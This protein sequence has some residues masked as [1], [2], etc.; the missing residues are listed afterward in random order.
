MVPAVA[1]NWPD[2]GGQLPAWR[3][4][5]R[6]DPASG[7][8]RCP[9]CR[10]RKREADR[11]A[12]AGTARRP[13]PERCAGRVRPCLPAGPAGLSYHAPTIVPAAWRLRISFVPSIAFRAGGSRGPGN[14]LPVWPVRIHR[15]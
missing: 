11:R 14:R 6:Y 15:D 4:P 5:R 7:A 2:R 1:G 10:F 8:C 9:A 3:A 12:A 13:L